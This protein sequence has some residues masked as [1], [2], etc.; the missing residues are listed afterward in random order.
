MSGQVD[1]KTVIG[2]DFGSD[3]AR[4][5]LVDAGTGEILAS[6][7]CPY[8]RW[9]N[10]YASVPSEARFR[11]HP[12]DHQEALRTIL[13]GVLDGFVRRETVVGIGV[14]ATASTPCL[15]DASGTP[16]A[17][18]PEFADDPDAMFVLWKDHT[19]EEEARLLPTQC[20]HLFTRKLLGKG[21]AYPAD[22]SRRGGKGGWSCRVV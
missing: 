10:G 16:L 2:V 15:T 1:G 9:T 4:A 13:H 3:S 8:A 17:L 12:L 14:D 7:S 11:Q 19:A 21:L 20:R 5:I 22:E 18:L 6:S